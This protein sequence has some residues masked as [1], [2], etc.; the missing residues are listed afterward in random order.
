MALADISGTVNNNSLSPKQ[1]AGTIK[2][3][4][5]GK[6]VL[7]PPIEDIIVVS[8]KERHLGSWEAAVHRHS[9]DRLDASNGSLL[10]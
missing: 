7:Q 10:K 8:A 3:M 1:L 2:T 9:L 4:N 6:M 5:H